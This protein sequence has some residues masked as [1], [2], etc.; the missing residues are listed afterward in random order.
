MLEQWDNYDI[1]ARRAEALFLNYDQEA[2]IRAFALKADKDHLYLDLLARPFRIDRR[3]GALER[4]PDWTRAGFNE[5]LSIFDA[6]CLSQR[7]FA[8]SGSWQIT[9]SLRGTAAGPASLETPGLAE[10]LTK[11]PAHLA[12]A[13]RALG[14]KEAAGGDLAFELPLLLGFS[15]LLRV[16]LADEEFP[17]QLQFFWDANALSFV[18][19]ETIFYL[20]GH[21]IDRLK[22]GLQC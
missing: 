2:L 1:A 14:G 3:T 4:G 6:L 19:Y 7:P 11:D 21:V 5:T 13:C 22:E 8:P 16:W 17:A 9:G 20:M 18:H 10:Q 12:S 15:T